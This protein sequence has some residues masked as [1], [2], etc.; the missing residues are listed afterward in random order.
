[1]E[2]VTTLKPVLKRGAL[3]AAANW[4]VT[5]I[6]ATADSLFKLLIATPVLGGVFLVALVAGTE[7]LELVN[8]DWRDLLATIIASLISHPLVLL[9]FLLAVAVTAIGGSL[10]VFLVKGGTV[11]TLIQGERQAGRIEDPPLHLEPLRQAAAFSV[12]AFA[13]AS[14]R[15]F[16][17]Y[18]RL[19]AV[20]MFVYGVSGVAY[21]AS[22]F[23]VGLTGETWGATVLVTVGFVSWIT[24]VNWIYLL[25]QIIVAADDCGTASAFSRVIAFLREDRKVAGIFLVM[26]ALIV[27]ATA[28]SWLATAALWLIG[29]VPVVGLAI[30]PLQLVAWLFR[31]IV[32]QFLDLS[33]IGAYARLYR[34]RPARVRHPILE[35]GSLNPD[36]RQ[37]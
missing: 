8:Q 29:F 7:P 30:I 4:Q 37:P 1:M 11:A 22:V 10:F 20:L 5:V 21:L 12:E 14:R 9:T 31:G 23:A 35:H 25:T 26:L 18:A 24:L 27:A 2:E 19:G 16:P 15:L 33:P 36:P 13:A 6:Q 32:F 3:L 34:E 28:V 17:R